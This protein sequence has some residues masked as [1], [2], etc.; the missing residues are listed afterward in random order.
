MWR[1][2]DDR[3]RNVH[4][5]IRAT[6]KLEDRR[7]GIFER[8][9]V[10]SV[11]V[12]DRSDSLPLDRSRDHRGGL[13]GRRGGLRKCRI[14]LRDVMPVDLYRVPADGAQATSEVVE[15]PTVHRLTPLAQPIDVQHGSEV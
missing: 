9:A 3:F 7:I 5:E 13:G 10:H 15:I 6:T 12:L 4:R 8:L 2:A 14:N 11:L 1:G